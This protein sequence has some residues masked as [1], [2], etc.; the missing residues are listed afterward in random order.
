M[1]IPF[2]KQ[3]AL[4]VKKIDRQA[5][6]FV[7]LLG[8]WV[9]NPAITGGQSHGG[10][11]T[12]G[13]Y[14]GRLS[15]ALAED[16]KNL[17]KLEPI[18]FSIEEF[19]KIIAASTLNCVKTTLL[20]GAIEVTARNSKNEKLI[21]VHQ[22]K[23]FRS[24]LSARRA[25]LLHEFLSLM[26][27]ENSLQYSISAPLSLKIDQ[28]LGSGSK[29]TAAE[30]SSLSKYDLDAALLQNSKDPKEIRA[31]SI[32]ILKTYFGFDEILISGEGAYARFLALNLRSILPNSPILR[33]FYSLKCSIISAINPPSEPLS[34]ADSSKFILRFENSNIHVGVKTYSGKKNQ[35]TAEITFGTNQ[36]ITSQNAKNAIITAMKSGSRLRCVDVE[37]AVR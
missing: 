7:T 30:N 25:L 21:E 15:L 22:T 6:I 23:F 20:V 33:E 9:A 5:A 35:D 18:P 2:K 10:G 1:D 32:A 34:A 27:L 28:R 4:S 3:T 37:Q 11:D 26:G 19:E 13:L 17:S 31:R 24:D 16:L 29:I 8:L 12:C 36:M 14:L